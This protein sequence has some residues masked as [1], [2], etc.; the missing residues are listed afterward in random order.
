MPFE[1]KK[2]FPHPSVRA[3]QDLAIN[4]VLDAFLNQGKKFVIL[5][6]GTG[7]GKSAIGVAVARY[8][9]SLRQDDEEASHLPGA[10][11]LTTQKVL[12][13]Q[14]MKDFG[15]PNGKMASI[16]S[17]ANYQ[18]TF[19]KNMMCSE[20]I[21]VLKGEKQGTP[22]WNS[23]MFNCCYKKEK[24]KFLESQESITNF[25][26]F[27]AETMYAGKI[28]PRDLLVVDEAHNAENELSKFVELTISEKFT[29][30]VLK[31]TWPK[32]R[33]QRDIYK[34]IVETYE[35]KLAQHIKRM[36]I[37][38]RKFK[39]DEKMKE[40]VQIAKQ[41]EM[42]DK[43]ICKIHR[44]VE[45]Y[46]HD[47]WVINHIPASGRSKR[48]FE[49]K[50]VDVGPF[51]DDMLFKFGKHVILMSATIVNKDVFCNCLG[52]EPTDAAF[53]S[54]DSPFPVSH[55]PIIYVPVGNMAAAQIDA[56][57]P[58]M[59]EAIKIILEQHKN[60]KG[61]IHT[62]TFKIA[63]YIK[64]AVKSRRLI[65]HDSFDR[66]EKYDKHVKSKKNTVLIS[67]S[68]SEGVDLKD[69]LSRFQVI[70]KIPYPYLGDKLVKKRMNK[71]SR[72]YPYQTAKGIVQAAGRSVRNENDRAVTYILDESWNYFFY[73]NPDMFP[74]SFKSALLT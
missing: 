73:K 1:Y 8:L 32:T 16:K 38:L 21:R 35:P 28:K 50:P 19:Y 64:K 39:I 63:N 48:K 46:E 57:L 20:S 67:P 10:Y 25:S 14:Y 23:C 15:P 11:T 36:D 56:S 30:E 41:H 53:L 43:H 24:K 59:A 42:L 66:Q 61:I 72:W 34:W 2:H 60:E 26:Y 29:K 51:S 3:E 47:N 71:R 18:C 27:L 17:A 6:L 33:A 65:I 62:H 37:M 5:E 7:C 44:F 13:E 45:L 58:K 40:F 49:F 74:T 9:S 4:F 54:L 68:M 31:L 12:Q 55:R 69:D 52:I 22:F 70:C